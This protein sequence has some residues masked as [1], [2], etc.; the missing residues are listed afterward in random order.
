[1]LCLNPLYTTGNVAV[2][3][4]QCAN[5]RINLLRIWSARLQLESLFHSESCFATLTYEDDQLPLCAEVALDGSVTDRPIPTLVP[6]HATRFIK[7][8]RNAVRHQNYTFRYFLVGEYGELGEEMHGQGRPHYHVL[9]FGLGED[10][11]DQLEEIWRKSGDSDEFP[12]SGGFVTCSEITPGRCSYAARYT[13][14]KLNG[15]EWSKIRLKGR[16]PEFSRMSKGGKLRGIGYPAIPWLGHTMSSLDGRKCLARYGDVWSS[17][18]IGGKI[19]PL[20]NYMRA[21]LRDYLEIPQNSR[22]RSQFFD[23]YDESTGELLEPP[24]LPANYCPREDPLEISTPLR[25][26][27]QKEIHQEKVAD[28]KQEAAKRER[29]YRRKRID[30]AAARF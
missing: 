18:R 1:M 2:P 17:I 26:K 13:M 7:H 8:V 5:C 23:F 24:P 30:R 9:F 20:G 10:R 12:H 15:D 29:S 11:E 6:E 3:C 28:L 22:E 16:Y 19:W 25:R 14:K 4:R 21:C 27:L